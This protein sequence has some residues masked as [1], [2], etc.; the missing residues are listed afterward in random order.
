[1]SKISK[2]FNATNNNLCPSVNCKTM[3][4]VDNHHI[5][6]IVAKQAHL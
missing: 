3:V 4:V 6:Q 1:M 2:L 5:V